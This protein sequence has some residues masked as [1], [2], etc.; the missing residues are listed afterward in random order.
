MFSNVF[1]NKYRTCRFGIT[2]HLSR[3]VLG[4]VARH[5]ANQVA[6]FNREGSFEINEGRALWPE[7]GQKRKGL[8][9]TKIGVRA[10]FTNLVGAKFSKWSANY[11]NM[12]TDSPKTN[13]KELIYLFIYLFIC[14][15][16]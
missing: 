8:C 10:N 4:Q 5:V 6:F 14:K 15:R 1:F 9:G 13:Y 16:A 12:G 2:S 3:Q 11:F 7:N